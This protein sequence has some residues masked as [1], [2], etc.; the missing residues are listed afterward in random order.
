M[1]SRER[2]ARSS[3]RH[4]VSP[5][6]AYRG[7]L[8]P[9]APL[10]RAP[11]RPLELQCGPSALHSMFRGFSLD[12]IHSFAPEPHSRDHGDSHQLITDSAMG[13]SSSS[14]RHTAQHTQPHSG[15]HFDKQGWGFLTH[16]AAPQQCFPPTA[17]EDAC[18]QPLG[19]PQSQE[20]S[21]SLASTGLLPLQAC[22]VC[23]CRS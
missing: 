8:I 21:L 18:S 11:G 9:L 10:T 4:P 5:N 19:R 22:Q 23:L 2:A 13:T 16:G 17:S 12:V 7:L 15:C 6:I 1:M 20:P 14:Q 3:V